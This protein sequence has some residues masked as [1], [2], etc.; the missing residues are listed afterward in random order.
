[1]TVSFEFLK[2]K[3]TKPIRSI[4]IQKKRPDSIFGSRV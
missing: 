4:T 1:M 2:N 3:E